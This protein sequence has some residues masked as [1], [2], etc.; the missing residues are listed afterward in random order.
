MSDPEDLDGV[1]PLPFSRSSLSPSRDRRSQLAAECSEDTFLELEV[2]REGR[3]VKKPKAEGGKKREVKKKRKS[4]RLIIPLPNLLPHQLI[5]P[6]RR[7]L[8]TASSLLGL[9]TGNDERHGFRIS[10]VNK[11]DRILGRFSF[12][13]GSR[14]LGSGEKDTESV[15]ERGS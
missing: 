8:I 3:G 1:H 14:S 7:L 12:K 15:G 9:H 4:Y 10:Y 13:A 6:V 11:V 5:H 2:E